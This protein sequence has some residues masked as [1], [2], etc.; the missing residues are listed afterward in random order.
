MAKK[1]KYIRVRYSKKTLPGT[2]RKMLNKRG[3][4][5]WE[6]F[7]QFNADGWHKSPWM[8]FHFRKQ[9]I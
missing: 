8:M 4:Q 5:G 9:I 2:I 7:S 3:L 6:L 1:Y